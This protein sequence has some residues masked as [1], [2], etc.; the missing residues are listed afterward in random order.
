M[1][2]RKYAS[3]F[4]LTLALTGSFL[5]GAFGCAGGRE[6]VGDGGRGHA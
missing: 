3:R 6:P 5:V 1:L 4:A 2:L